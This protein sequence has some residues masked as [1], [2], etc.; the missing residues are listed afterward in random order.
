MERYLSS[1]LPA[2]LG[3]FG[4][5]FLVLGFW[6][7]V[8]EGGGKLFFY[9][10]IRIE[11]R[12]SFMKMFASFCISFLF[13]SGSSVA[14][15]LCQSLAVVLLSLSL[16]PHKEFRFLLPVLPVCWCLVADAM[17]E[18]EHWV[19]VIFIYFHLLKKWVW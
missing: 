17:Q 9:H 1:G 13:R 7:R 4:V 11:K 10:Y 12:H 5:P 16:V 2:V 18:R 3:G 19:L 14:G 6:R 15:I 8:K